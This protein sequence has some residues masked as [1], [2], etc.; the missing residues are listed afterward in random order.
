MVFS[1]VARTYASKPNRFQQQPRPNGAPHLSQ[2]SR[3]VD[4]LLSTLDINRDRVENEQSI[5]K[6][7]GESRSKL[8]RQQRKAEKLRLEL[9]KAEQKVQEAMSRSQAQA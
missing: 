6:E 4:I 2:S 7:E 5:K 1:N 8:E 9:E 3:A